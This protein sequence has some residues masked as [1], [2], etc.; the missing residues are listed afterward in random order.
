VALRSI[1][2]VLQSTDSLS[3]AILSS[4]LVDQMS[5]GPACFPKGHIGRCCSRKCHRRNRSEH[6]ECICCRKMQR[7]RQKDCR[8]CIPHQCCSQPGR[9]KIRHTLW[10][11]RTGRCLPSTARRRHRRIPGRSSCKVRSKER[12]KSLTSCKCCMC[13]SRRSCHKHSHSQ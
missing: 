9:C 8:C 11:G 1:F 13:R 3:E 2:S 4:V 10:A 5:A 12:R 7:R 6:R